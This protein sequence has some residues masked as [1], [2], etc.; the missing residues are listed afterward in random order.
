MENLVIYSRLTGML[1]RLLL[2]RDGAGPRAAFPHVWFL[3]LQPALGQRPAR[4]PQTGQ[5]EPHAVPL[6]VT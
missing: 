6:N 1:L 4:S 5:N 2:P 3:F